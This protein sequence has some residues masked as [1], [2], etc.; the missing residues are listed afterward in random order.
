FVGQLFGDRILLKQID[1]SDPGH[2]VNRSGVHPFSFSRGPEA[3][4][5]NAVERLVERPLASRKIS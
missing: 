4:H 2:P 5:R 3:F 1:L